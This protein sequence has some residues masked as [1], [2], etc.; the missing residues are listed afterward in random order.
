M[1]WSL[2]ARASIAGLV[3]AGFGAAEYLG[4]TSA[5]LRS[6]AFLFAMAGVAIC[7]G[8]LETATRQRAGWLTDCYV[9]WALLNLLA[10]LFL[11]LNRGIT[12]QYLM[13]IAVLAPLWI[14]F[15]SWFAWQSHRVANAPGQPDEPETPSPLPFPRR[16]FWLA[17]FLIMVWTA[18]LPV[19]KMPA[20]DRLMDAAAKGRKDRFAACLE[21]VKAELP[22]SAL[23]IALC[24]ACDRHHV[25]LVD[26]LLTLGP[27]LSESPD[28]RR[29]QPLWWALRGSGS[30]EVAERLLRA[31]APVNKPFFSSRQEKPL[32]MVLSMR[33]PTEQTIMFIRL[34][35]SHGADLGAPVDDQGQFPVEAALL[36]DDSTVVVPELIRLGADPLKTTTNNLFYLALL[37]RQPDILKLLMDAGLSPTATDSK[38]NTFLHIMTMSNL[39]A[40]DP[41]YYGFTEYLPAV[42][43]TRNAEG[44]TPLHLAVDANRLQDVQTLLSW[45]ANPHAP[46][47]KGET[48]LDLARRKRF[49]RLAELMEQARP[50]AK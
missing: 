45:N 10:A 32:G 8:N 41:L 39:G 3:I 19:L 30:V 50:T 44:K 1:N 17:V 7:I 6:A 34:L 38:G 43:D 13:S 2:P 14:V 16:S 46:D 20:L 37:G 28:G 49:L 4:F 48:P 22:G 15:G 21:D 31:G 26:W 18:L 35:A 42:I 27:N 40:R 5:A 47:P 36:R 25:E 33:Y 12:R 23:E 29:E 24:E 11:I 9:G